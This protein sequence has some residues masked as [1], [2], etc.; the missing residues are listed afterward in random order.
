V[1][2]VAVA[3]Q[4]KKS[5]FHLTN[6][7]IRILVAVFALQT[8]VLLAFYL[9]SLVFLSSAPSKDTLGTKDFVCLSCIMDLPYFFVVH[10][11]R[12]AIVDFIIKC[13]KK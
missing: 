10:Q 9:L 5:C 2:S 8:T 13:C 6:M 1:F 3:Y 11:V 4:S 12:Q 7:F